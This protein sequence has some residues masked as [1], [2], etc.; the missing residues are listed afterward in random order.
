MAQKMASVYGDRL[1][2]IFTKETGYLIDN[3]AKELT[4]T[5]SA[6]IVELLLTF[7]KMDKEK[8]FSQMAI[9]IWETTSKVNQ[10]AKANIHG[11]MEVAIRE[12]L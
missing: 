3:M 8:N 9:N 2:E 7:S 12:N 5:V 11:L 6:P 1:G 4:N 10:M